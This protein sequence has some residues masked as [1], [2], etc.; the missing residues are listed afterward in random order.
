[1]AV[2]IR[3]TLKLGE[4]EAKMFKTLIV[5]DN[6]LIRE[7]LKGLFTRHFSSMIVEEASDGKKAMEKVGF[8]QPDLILMDLRLPGESGLEL[9]QKIKIMDSNV[10][11]VILT[12]DHAPEYKEMAARYG[13]DGFL[14]KG[15]ASQ[16][17]LAV[18]GSFLSN[19][20][21]STVSKKQ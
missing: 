20:E 15:G 2:D 14:V 6:A 9:T 4:P 11:V 17:I 7:T 12:G 13:A 19:A 16:E 1:M 10:K 21:E 5:E 18:V 8:F 3:L